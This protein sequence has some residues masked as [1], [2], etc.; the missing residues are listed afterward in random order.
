MESRWILQLHQT[1]D[2]AVLRGRREIGGSREAEMAGSTTTHGIEEVRC[3]GSGTSPAGSGYHQR[4]TGH[5]GDAGSECTAPVRC[6]QFEY[7]GII[8]DNRGADCNSW[9]MTL[10]PRDTRLKDYIWDVY[11]FLHVRAGRHAQTMATTGAKERFSGEDDAVGSSLHRRSESLKYRKCAQ[12]IASLKISHVTLK[13]Y[14]LTR[15]I[16]DSHF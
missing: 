10:Q 4:C 13:Q 7:A 14:F 11:M 12:R 2:G 6:M 9:S 3:V 15:M 1:R 16:N 5:D 8:D